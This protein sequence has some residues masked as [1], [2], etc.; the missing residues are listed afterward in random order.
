MDARP[1]QADIDRA[2]EVERNVKEKD[3]PLYL[4]CMNGKTMK[5]RVTPLELRSG[6]ILVGVFERCVEK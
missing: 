4:E 5:E 3:W 1:P 6:C 2:L